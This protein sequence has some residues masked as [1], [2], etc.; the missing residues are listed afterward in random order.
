M[1]IYKKGDVLADHRDRESCEISA[2]LN[3]SGEKWPIFFKD[4][5]KPSIKVVLKPGDLAI[6]KGCELNHWREAFEGEHCAQVFLHYTSEKNKHL[7]FDG[8][9]MPGLP[10][11]YKEGHE[12]TYSQE[13]LNIL[14]NKVK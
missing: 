12:F 8:R 9:G 3:L 13:N 1:R 6:Y 7:E 10:G 2:T 4:G 11:V 5:D 14:K